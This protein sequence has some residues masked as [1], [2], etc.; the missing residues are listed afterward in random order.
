MNLRDYFTTHAWWG[1]LIGAFLGYLIAGSAG[2]LFG[3]LI[4]NFFDRGLYEH[5]AKPHWHYHAEK[6]KAVQRIFFEVTF[7]VMGHIAK[8]DGRVS[9]Q[10]IKMAKQLMA[11]MELNAEQKKAAQTFYNQGKKSD[12][13]LIQM[14]GSLKKGCYDNPELLKL[15]IDLQYRAAQ[16]DGLSEKK[17]QAINIIFKQLGL[18]PIQEQYRYYEDFTYR[19]HQRST[20]DQRQQQYSSSNQRQRYGNSP[21]KNTLNHAFSILEV[22]PTSTKHEV[23]RAYRRLISR[24]HPDKLIAKGLPEEMIKMATDKT[25]KISKAY[26]QICEIKGW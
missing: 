6:R 9:E 13:D 26:E 7:S 5:F 22:A 3:I 19:P 10:D 20:H 23:K 11:E 1:K 25:Q 17:I 24:N 18:A 21:P 2:A 14:L 15:F 8:S 12:F 16:I 4:G